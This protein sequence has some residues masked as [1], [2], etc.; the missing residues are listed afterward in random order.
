MFKDQ[1]NQLRILPPTEGTLEKAARLLFEGELVAIPT[2]TVYGLAADATNDAAVA[3]IYSLKKRPQFNPLI[4]HFA[5]VEQI[6]PHVEWNEMAEKLA[7]A[8]WPGPL[9][10]VLKKKSSSSLSLLATAGLETVGVRIPHHEVTSLLIQKAGKPLAAPSANPSEAISPTSAEDVRK[11]FDPET[12]LLI[13]EGG[14]C[15]GGI[16][17]TIVDLTLET[18]TLLRPGLALPEKIEAILHRPVQFLTTVSSI[19]APGQMKRHYAPDIPLRLNA[20][21]VLPGEALLAFGPFP[22][23]GAAK[24]LNLSHSGDLAE[25]AANLFAMMRELDTPL[26]SSIAVMPIPSYG[27]GLAINDRLSRAATQKEE[28]SSLVS[29]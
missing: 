20:T 8:F 13:I 17:S 19:K 7:H 3:K 25:A 12:P 26:F 14:I 27:I 16:E 28:T 9:T 24:T 1:S 22:L 4:I 18:P 10:L 11:G 2:E 29:R 6:K 21:T 15:Q 5:E 23:R